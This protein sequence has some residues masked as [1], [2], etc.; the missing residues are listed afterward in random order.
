VRRGVVFLL[1]VPLVIGACGDAKR[2]GRA[3]PTLE[4]GDLAPAFALP[5][6]EGERLALEDLKGRPALFYFSMGPG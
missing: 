1:L 3:I 2:E 6:A 5:T 4:P